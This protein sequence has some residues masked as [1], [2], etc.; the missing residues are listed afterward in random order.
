[1]FTKSKMEEH[2]KLRGLTTLLCELTMEK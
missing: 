1:V 2:F